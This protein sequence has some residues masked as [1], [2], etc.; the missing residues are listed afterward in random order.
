M[1]SARPFSSW[2]MA[3]NPSGSTASLQTCLGTAPHRPPELTIEYLMDGAKW[4]LRY[5][6]DITF[7]SGVAIA[8]DHYKYENMPEVTL[9]APT[10]TG[11]MASIPVRS[12]QSYTGRKP[13]IPSTLADTP[14]ANF[15]VQKLLKKFNTTLGTSY[16]RPTGGVYSALEDCISKNYDFGT[17]Y[18]HLRPFWNDLEKLTTIVDELS[19]RE[20]RYQK[21]LQDVLVED[22]IISTSVPP[23][24]VWDLYSNR[25]V[26]YWVARQW[27][28]GISH[29][30]ADEDDREDALTPI[31]GREWPVPIPKGTSLNLIRIEM[32]NLGAEYAWLD[33]LCL[34]QKGG[35]RAREDLREKEWKV[36]VPTIGG[37]YHN[38]Y[39]EVVFY[40]SG[41][42]PPLNSKADDLVSDRCWFKRAWTL[43]EMPSSEHPVIIGG[44]TGDT[45]LRDKL[46]KLLWS[47][48]NNGRTYDVL[49]Q[50]QKRVSTKSVDKVVGLAYLLRSDFMPAYYES[51]SEEDAWTALVAVAGGWSQAELLFL[52]PKPGDGNKIWRPSWKQVMTEELPTRS[53]LLYRWASE[54]YVDSYPGKHAYIIESAS[55]RGLSKGDSQGKDRRGHIIV[56]DNTGTECIFDIV[57]R[58]QYPIPDDSYTLLGTI[59]LSEA[60]DVLLCV[61]WVVGRRL[62]DQRLK[63]LS[64][65]EMHDF[66][67]MHD[68]QR[69]F[70]PRYNQTSLP[71]GV[72]DS[73]VRT[74]RSPLRPPHQPRV[75]ERFGFNNRTPVKMTSMV[76][77][78][79]ATKAPVTFLA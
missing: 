34:R 67:E 78:G 14:C 39:A 42:G 46:E 3:S 36:D 10:E 13:V 72:L 11:Q 7:K 48:K 6:D 18:A 16:T 32:L 49:P 77:R 21:M 76:F 37:V 26:P 20:V 17:A 1:A 52:Y 58:H 68:P 22:R 45:G 57:A 63:K 35:L 55:V 9:S 41:L 38:R 8:L 28:W 47:L 4:Y 69:M 40:L 64:V 51:Q 79:I 5:F 71:D 2:D 30:W 61:C 19:N 24:R 25:V 29:S 50:M 43:Q 44:D 23:R 73:P 59:G 75:R 65:F 15:T 12:Q 56:K 74:R 27:P 66:E 60:A 33:V 54:T 53:P 62:Q 31:N 70:R